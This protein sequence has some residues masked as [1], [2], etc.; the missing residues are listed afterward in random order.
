MT[1]IMKKNNTKNILTSEN[2]N[3]VEKGDE[4]E[5][6]YLNE[7]LLKSQRGTLIKKKY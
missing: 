6:F 2:F 4:D 5:D 7:K 1:G 3:D